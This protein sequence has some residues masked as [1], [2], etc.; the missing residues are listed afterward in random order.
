MGKPV[1]PP[2]TADN[3]VLLIVGVFAAAV[4]AAIAYFVVNSAAKPTAVKLDVPR[5]DDAGTDTNRVRGRRGGLAA[6]RARRRAGAT[7]DTNTGVDGNESLGE[8]A[9]LPGASDTEDISGKQSK[10]IGA[11]K[12]AKL[13]AKEARREAREAAEREREDAK[14]RKQLRWEQEQKAREAEEA[15]AQAEEEKRLA[16][17]AE[18]KRKEEE[19]YQA[20]KGMFSVDESGSRADEEDGSSQARLEDFISFIRDTKVVM[21]EELAAKFNLKTSDA[22]SRIRSLEEDGRLTGVMDDRGKYIYVSEDE[23]KAVVKFMRQRGRVTIAE[24]A[25]HSPKLVSLEGVVAEA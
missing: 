14:K 19:E 25:E 7:V 23:M 16:E 21:L 12:A 17:E 8:D 18:Q 11:K 1:Q 22:V 20:M 3:S 4:I 9:A 6:L 24:L 5:E 15:A 10:K 13:E 2:P